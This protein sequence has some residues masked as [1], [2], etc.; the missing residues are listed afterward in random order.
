ML[1]PLQKFAV[2]ARD[3]ASV[4]ERMSEREEEVQELKSERANTRVRI[5]R[6]GGREGGGGGGGLYGWGWLMERREGEGGRVGIEAE[7]RR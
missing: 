6:G 3:L 5:S 4:K 7:E 1:L 2:L